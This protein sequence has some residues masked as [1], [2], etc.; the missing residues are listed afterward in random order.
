[1]ILYF[2]TFITDK[3]LVKWEA[4]D[5]LL[6]QVRNSNLNYKPQS[7]IDIVKYTLASYSVI[8]WSSVYIKF[9]IEDAELSQDFYN[10]VKNLFPNSRIEFQRSTNQYQYLETIKYLKSL[11]DKWIF[12]APN[13]D[14]PFVANNIEIL[15]N[16]ISQADILRNQLLT[17]YISITYSHFS[18]SIN[19][20]KNNWMYDDN[21]Q[22]IKET[23]DYFLIRYPLGYLIAISIVNIDLFE[24][25]F[26]GYNYQEKRII[27]T[28]DLIGYSHPE[29]FVIVPKLELCRHYD[30]YAHTTLLYNDLRAISFNSVPPL[31]IPDGFFE[32]NIRINANHNKYKKNWVNINIEKNK[33]SFQDNVNGT[34]LKLD[35]EEI[36]LFWKSRISQVSNDGNSK[37]QRN[38][39]NQIIANPI[40]AYPKYLIIFQYGKY[41]FK[42]LYRKLNK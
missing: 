36:P 1:M 17:N 7:K 28:E 26:T 31:F 19:I 23:S 22:I 27:R 10:Y 13:N 39:S 14:H 32:N 35:I 5:Q 15:N 37:K 40:L 33:Y 21:V 18:E 3:S 25:W 24:Q 8:K 9:E 6:S 29:Q 4:L 42:K 20:C 41:L 38:K 11:G 30:S 2:D 34:D 16:I 12:Y